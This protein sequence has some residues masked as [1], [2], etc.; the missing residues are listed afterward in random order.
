M[1]EKLRYIP[2]ISQE[3]MVPIIELPDERQLAL[4]IAGPKEGTPI[5]GFHGNPGSRLG[6][7]PRS[8]WLHMAG[9]RLISF[10]R[11]GYGMS[12]RNPGRAIRDTAADVEAIADCLGIE[13][14]AVHARSGGVPHAL[15]CAALLKDRVV[16]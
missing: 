3:E 16:N 11:P 8:H 2:D 13:Q 1:A 7:W 5:I 10:D 6:P 12:T 14:F 4:K 9:I 15:G